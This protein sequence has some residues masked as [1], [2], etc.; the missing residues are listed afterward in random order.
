MMHK[1]QALMMPITTT[2]TTNAQLLAINNAQVLVMSP[3]QS[4]LSS[5]ASAISFASYGHK[6]PPQSRIECHWGFDNFCRTAE[7]LYR[8]LWLLLGLTAHT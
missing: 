1:G 5:P 2:T 6:S 8:F 4:F 7:K 3:M